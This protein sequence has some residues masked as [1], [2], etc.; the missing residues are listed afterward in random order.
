[1]RNQELFLTDLQ[2]QTTLMYD[3]KQFICDRKTK[4]NLLSDYYKPYYFQIACIRLEMQNRFG[5]EEL[6][7]ANYEDLIE[8]ILQNQENYHPIISQLNLIKTQLQEYE[9]HLQ[10]SSPR[11]LTYL[12]H[13][14][15]DLKKFIGAPYYDPANHAKFLD[16][17]KNYN[18]S[19]L[20]DF[21]QNQILDE[22]LTKDNIKKLINIL[23]S[24]KRE[25][26]RSQTPLKK[27]LEPYPQLVNQLYNA[28]TLINGLARHYY[29]IFFKPDVLKF[30]KDHLELLSYLLDPNYLPPDGVLLQTIL[31]EITKIINLEE[32]IRYFN[33]FVTVCDQLAYFSDYLEMY[34]ALTILLHDSLEGL[35]ILA[36]PKPTSTLSKNIL[37]TFYKWWTQPKNATEATST[38][39]G[40]NA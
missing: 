37:R 12:C 36:H 8:C 4:A 11:P 30:F 32:R 16:R 9:Y 5:P 21:L 39:P 14:L 17:N 13:L 25:D 10:R 3:W 27:F 1:M 29:R 6:A 38:R 31:S 15:I 18:S 35:K 26:R 24:E 2:V 28:R 22:H 19:V 7:S 20:Y 34:P 23:N 33:G 40:L